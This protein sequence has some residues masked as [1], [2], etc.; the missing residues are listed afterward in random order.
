MTAARRELPKQGGFCTKTDSFCHPTGI[1]GA[2]GENL[3]VGFDQHRVRG[4]ARRQTHCSSI[5][6]THPCLPPGMDPTSGCPRWR[7][8]GAPSPRRI[9][10][11]APLQSLGEALG[12]DGCVAVSGRGFVCQTGTCLCQKVFAKYPAPGVREDKFFN[13]VKMIYLN[14]KPCHLTSF[15]FSNCLCFFWMINLSSDSLN[16]T[17]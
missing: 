4:G 12:R 16:M 1:A 15:H 6:P 8:W 13:H 11:W 7:C 3:C 17:N 9:P 5:A 2:V 10:G 14:V